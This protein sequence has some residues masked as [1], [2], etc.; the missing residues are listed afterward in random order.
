MGRP[1]KPKY[2]LEGSWVDK[3]E[4][5][6]ANKLFTVILKTNHFDRDSDIELLKRLV[7]AIM[8][9]IRIEKEITGKYITAK[10][11]DSDGNLNVK[12][13]PINRMLNATYN[14]SLKQILDLQKQLGMLGDKSKTNP[15]QY[16]F[17]LMKKFKRWKE[18]NQDGR[19]CTCPF[20]SEVFF[21]NIRTDKYESMKHPYFIGKILGN[22]EIWKWYKAGMITKTQF[23]IAF[24]TSEF[25]IDW[26]EEQIE[27]KKIKIDKD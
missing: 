15:L 17:R 24:N 16:I 23:A 25:Y 11:P 19:K 22:P 10:T 14:E 26:L 5:K 4:E 12:T 6:E 1:K 8:N 2:T 9:S 7:F 13:S 18:D 20:C 27:Q 3:N 21:L